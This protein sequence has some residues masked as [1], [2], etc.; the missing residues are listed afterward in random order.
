MDWGK[1]VLSRRMYLRN[2]KE[3]QVAGVR[4]IDGGGVAGGRLDHAGP[5][6]LHMGWACRILQEL[7]LL[8]WKTWKP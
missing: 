5:R 8:F 4:G 6:R 2:T 3:A 1:N 7:W